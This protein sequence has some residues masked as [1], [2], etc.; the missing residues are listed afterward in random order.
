MG[1]MVLKSVPRR[2]PWSAVAGWCE[3]HG[4]DADDRAFLY[5]LIRAM[6]GEYL[7]HWHRKESKG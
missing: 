4:R 3:L 1:G 6:D 2:I 7:A 5:R